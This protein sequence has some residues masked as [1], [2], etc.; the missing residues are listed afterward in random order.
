MA[1]TSQE[2]PKP[3]EAAEKPE[4]APE[5]AVLE[6]RVNL[7]KQQPKQAASAL[8]FIVAV[9]GFFLF[10]FQNLVWAGFAL[11]ML[12]IF[13]REFFLPVRY[14]LTTK[15]AEMRYLGGWYRMEWKDVKACYLDECGV[16]LSPFRF[17]TRLDR[18]RG[19]YL[20]FGDNR[21][22]VVEKVKE[23]A[24]HRDLPTETANG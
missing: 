12:L 16:K 18:F 2:S 7:R 19:I 11:V 5:T 24:A 8:F 3:S 4:E 15:A 6:W 14:R 1:Q 17:R 10:V 9:S 23:L 20:R 21:E 13:T 22:A